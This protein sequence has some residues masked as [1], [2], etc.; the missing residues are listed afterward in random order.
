MEINESHQGS[1]DEHDE[2]HR[3]TRDLLSRRAWKATID[4]GKQEVEDQVPGKGLDELSD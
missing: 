1:S 2:A 3:E 4:R